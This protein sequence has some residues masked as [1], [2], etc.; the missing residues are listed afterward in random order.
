MGVHVCIT[1]CLSTHSLEVQ[2]S[3]TEAVGVSL[4]QFQCMCFIQLIV[5]HIH[6]ES[7]VCSTC[8][9]KNCSEDK[10]SVH[11]TPALPTELNSTPQNNF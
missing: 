2:Y 1:I 7:F 9:W 3:S 5:L 8:I 10:A 11:G 4:Y 6:Y